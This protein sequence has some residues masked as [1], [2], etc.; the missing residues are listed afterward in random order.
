MVLCVLAAAAAAEGE[1]PLRVEL[2][3]TVQVDVGYARGWMCDDPSLVE[4]DMTTK[5]DHNVWVVRGVKLGHTLC[6]VGT[7][8]YASAYVFDLR[9]VPAKKR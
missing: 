9:I 2:G 3:K 4:A 5:G 6:R 1:R 8:A 7:D